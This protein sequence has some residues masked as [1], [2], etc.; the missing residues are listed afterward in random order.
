MKIPLHINP[1]DNFF[2]KWSDV[3]VLSSVQDCV[4]KS[5][6]YYKKKKN[7]WLME[8]KCVCVWMNVR[9]QNFF[10]L[11]K[12]FISTNL[13]ICTCMRSWWLCYTSNSNNLTLCETFS[14]ISNRNGGRLFCPFTTLKEKWAEKISH[15]ETHTS[16]FYCS[17]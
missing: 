8:K 2:H 4:V 12:I 11:L 5:A 10:F 13:S 16:H 9:K 15:I 1:V 14:F 17:L 7:F 3:Y 6:F